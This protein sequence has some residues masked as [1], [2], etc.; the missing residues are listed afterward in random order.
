MRP[1]LIPDERPSRNGVTNSS[2]L[3]LDI[4]KLTSFVNLNPNFVIKSLFGL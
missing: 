1:S 4:V 2:N 3:S